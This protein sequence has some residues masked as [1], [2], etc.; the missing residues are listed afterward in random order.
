MPTL[1]AAAATYCGQNLGAGKYD[2]IFKGM[3][4][5]FWICIGCAV[6][7]AAINCFVGPHMIG[8]FITS[9]TAV[10]MDYAMRYLRIASIFMLPLA[11]IFAYRNGL[12]GLN[13]GLV[14]MLS[15]VMEL[16]A[17]VIAIAILAKPFGYTGVCYADPAAWLSTGVLLI[18]TY[19]IWELRTKKKIA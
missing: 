18:V 14:P 4:S 9:P 17:R 8:W 3:R 1:G 7:A 2:R 15:G 11:W 16:A 12:Q 19:L 5:C 13:R 10:D 6:L